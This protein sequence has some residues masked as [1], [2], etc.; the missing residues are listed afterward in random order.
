MKVFEIKITD[1]ETGKI[2]HTTIKVK[3]NQRL[4][5]IVDKAYNKC[6]VEIVKAELDKK[7]ES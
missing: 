2:Q 6:L 1:F 4:S 7:K 3:D 5:E